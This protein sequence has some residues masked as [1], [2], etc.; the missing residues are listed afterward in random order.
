MKNNPKICMVSTVIKNFKSYSKLIVC[1][2]GIHVLFLN[3]SYLVHKYLEIMFWKKSIKDFHHA[4]AL[5]SWRYWLRL[6]LKSNEWKIKQMQFCYILW[7]DKI[8]WF[9]WR[10]GK[11]NSVHKLFRNELLHF[12]KIPCPTTMT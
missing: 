1:T 9:F 6:R 2:T 3:S 4:H 8:Q 10:H 11:G 12:C 5:F 7:T